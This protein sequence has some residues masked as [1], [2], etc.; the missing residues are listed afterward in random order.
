MSKTL[1]GRKLRM[2]HMFDDNG[3]LV[4]LTALQV[5]PCPVV[6]I[7]RSGNDGYTA[8]Q[9][10]FGEAKEQR[11]SRPLLGQFERAGVS[12]TRYLREVRCAEDDLPEV[13]S[14]LSVDE[15]SEGQIVDVSGTSKGK[16]FAGVVK[17]HGFAG[18]RA[19]HGQME[20][21][22]PGSI[23]SSAYP[24]R[25]FKGKRMAG[26]M[27]GNQVTALGLTVA[28]IDS[29]NHLLYVKGSI[30]GPPGRLVVVRPSNRGKVKKDRG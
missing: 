25:V 1:L 19:T 20:N 2:T 13:G 11:V 22:V 18:Y 8:Y 6:Q 27:G 21:R 5:G 15:F 24:S 28:K 16:G 14:T 12:P 23:G 3:A 30:P 26:R 9:I 17:R 29:E 10:G 4:P 7:K